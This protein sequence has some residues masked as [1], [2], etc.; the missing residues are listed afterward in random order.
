MLFSSIRNIIPAFQ[1]TQVVKAHHTKQGHS[2]VTL[3]EKTVLNDLQL[4]D[5]DEVEFFFYNNVST[6]KQ[7][8]FSVKK[9]LVLP[10]KHFFSAYKVPLYDLYCN[11]KFH[12]S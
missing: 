7:P 12:L 10:E 3:L 1:D 5:A 2:L 8:A 9:N 4:D 11:W 6:Q